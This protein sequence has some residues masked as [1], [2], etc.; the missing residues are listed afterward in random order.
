VRQPDQHVNRNV[1]RSATER[2]AYTVPHANGAGSAPAGVILRD[3]HDGAS[4][5]NDTWPHAEVLAAPTDIDSG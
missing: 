3:I 5:S 4:V 1:Q 2:L